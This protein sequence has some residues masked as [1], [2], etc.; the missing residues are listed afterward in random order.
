MHRHSSHSVFGH[1]GAL[2]VLAPTTQLR[3][4]YTRGFQCHLPALPQS[5]YVQVIEWIHRYVSQGL[6]GAGSMTLII[7]FP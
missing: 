1:F 6:V 2:R 5:V 4:S 7:T 3:L